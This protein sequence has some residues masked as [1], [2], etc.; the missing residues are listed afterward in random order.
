MHEKVLISIRGRRSDE[1]ETEQ[2]ELLIPGTYS[3]KNGVHHV[4]YEEPADPDTGLTGT[5]L[6]TIRIGKNGMQIIKKGLLNTR[7]SFLNTATRTTTSYRTPYGAF[8]LGIR[9][10]DLHFT[11]TEEL[12]AAHVDYRLDV[13]NQPLSNCVLDIEIRPRTA[14]GS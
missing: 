4:V 5:T 3:G 9:T 8:L 1:A 12:L 7:M 10:N 6:N 2:I 13:N 11:D 14:E